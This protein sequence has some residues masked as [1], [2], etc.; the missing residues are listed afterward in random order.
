MVACG[1]I[2]SALDFDSKGSR[3][4]PWQANK[5][6]IQNVKKQQFHRHRIWG[7]INDPIY[8]P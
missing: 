7:C 2:G 6:L 5:K 3:F 4:D 1:A 8:W